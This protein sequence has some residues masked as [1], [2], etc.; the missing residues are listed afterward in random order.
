MVLKFK[1]SSWLCKTRWLFAAQSQYLDILP[2]PISGST[3]HAVPWPRLNNSIKEGQGVIGLPTKGQEKDYC[4]MP[5]REISL[6]GKAQQSHFVHWQ[7]GPTDGGKS[8]RLLTLSSFCYPSFRL[9][10]DIESELILVNPI[11]KDILSS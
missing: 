7:N 2:M 1:T 8:F 5:Y 3:V 9:A 11:L 4:K 10:D 6:L